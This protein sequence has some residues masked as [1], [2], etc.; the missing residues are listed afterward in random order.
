M[1]SFL[2]IAVFLL[3]A[4]SRRVI[5]TGYT[6]YSPI[7]AYLLTLVYKAVAPLT[8]EVLLVAKRMCLYVP[9]PTPNLH[10]PL[11]L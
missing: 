5:N 1:F 9:K 3:W 2:G 8:L 4:V 7:V 11:H 6:L 10:L